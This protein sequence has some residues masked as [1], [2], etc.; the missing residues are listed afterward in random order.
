MKKVIRNLSIL[1]ILFCLISLGGGTYFINYA[2]VP[3]IAQQSKDENPLQSIRKDYPFM[4]SWLDSLNQADAIRDTF[5]T[6]PQGL[7]YHAIYVSATHK[8]DKTA[9]IIHGYTDC[10]YRMMMIGYLYQHDLGYNI[11]LP[12]LHF[13]GQSEGNAV[14]M[15]WMD[16]LD[17]L[18]W[19]NVANE[20]FGGQT[21]MVVHGI[22]MGA[23]TTMMLS[24]ENTPDYT[25]CFVE[26]CGYTSVW[27]EFKYKLNESFNIPTFPLLN[28]TNIVCHMRY[29]WGFKEASA[30]KQVKKCEKPM[31]FIHGA[32]DKYV[33]T[34]MVKS[35]YA[36]KPEPKELWIAPNSKHALSYHD[37]HDEYTAKVKAFV[38]KYIH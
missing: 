23:A 2:L 29:G 5:I 36:A 3:T 33:P 6:N 35:L 15:G 7:R 17:A 14:Q 31:F 9:F 32:K 37:H 30:L 1:I 20:V 26:D 27:D 16:R 4:N 21:Q 28:A 38:T 8:T 24:G 12:D 34:W 22:S 25:H 18:S 19:M 13:H 10:S 11:F